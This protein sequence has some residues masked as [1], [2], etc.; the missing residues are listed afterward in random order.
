MRGAWTVAAL[1]VGALGIVVL[2][3]VVRCAM[4][5]VRRSGRPISARARSLLQLRLRPL[6][7]A[8]VEQHERTDVLLDGVPGRQRSHRKRRLA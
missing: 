7:V 5:S 6:H 2:G 1:I 8:R 4:S 3:I